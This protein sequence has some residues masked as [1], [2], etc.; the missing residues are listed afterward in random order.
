MAGIT[1]LGVL[2]VLRV[3]LM[4]QRASASHTRSVTTRRARMVGGLRAAVGEARLEHKL[5]PGVSRERLSQRVD[6][7]LE[8]LHRPHTHDLLEDT[9]VAREVFASISV[10]IRIR[11]DDGHLYSTVSERQPTRYSSTITH[12]MENNAAQSAV[13]SETETTEHALQPRESKVV[14]YCLLKSTQSLGS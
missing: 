6:L 3:Q 2:K 11:R 12:Q 9:H 5:F 10:Q 7:L 13:D 8:V 4:V 1:D 14:Q